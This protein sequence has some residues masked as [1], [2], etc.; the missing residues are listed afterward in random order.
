MALQLSF[1]GKKE[2]KNMKKPLVFSVFLKFF[3]QISVREKVTGR[4]LGD[5]SAGCVC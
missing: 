1:D 3:R 5:Q 2:K 4:L